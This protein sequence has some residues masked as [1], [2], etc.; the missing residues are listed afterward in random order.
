MREIIERIEQKRNLS[1]GQMHAVMTEIMSGRASD[2]DIKDFLLGLNAKGFTVEEITAGA[3][4]MRKFVIPVK[5]DLTKVFDIV[6]TGGDVKHSFNIST[7]AAFVVAAAGVPV[8]K[9]GNRSVSSLCGSADVLEA[10]GVNINT[11]HELLDECLKEVG[12]VFLFAQ[13]H[14]PAMK[15]VAAVRKELGVKT[16]FNILGP[17]T[18]PAFATH[19]MMG[20]YSRHLTEQM[21]HVLKN[22]GAK[23]VIA[24]HSHDGFDEISSADKTLICDLQDSGVLTY[25]ITPEDFGIKRCLESDLKGGDRD[26]N[27]H[28][29]R[30]ILEG[31][32]GSKRDIVLLNAGFGLYVAEAVASPKEGLRLAGELIDSGRALKKLEQLKEFTHRG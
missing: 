1:H 32:K 26:E 24:V 31:E 5:T 10:L 6:G 13:H 11:P 30:A 14:H 2:V 12:I 18:N 27:A 8:A 22:L 25:E 16:I 20:V 28:I 9:H 15:H 17:L 7:A 21:V 3:E 23:R 29:L 19:Q 4:I